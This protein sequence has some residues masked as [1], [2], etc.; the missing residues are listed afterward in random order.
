MLCKLIFLGI[1]VTCFLF[2]F[3]QTTKFETIQAF[4]PFEILEIQK[5]AE[6]AEIKKAFRKLSLIW[7]PDKNRNNPLPAAAKFH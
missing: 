7:H 6:S 1:L 5:G 4:D 2:C 3:Y